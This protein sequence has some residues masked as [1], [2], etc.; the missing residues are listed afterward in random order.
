L[1]III[2]LLIIFRYAISALK[3]TPNDLRQLFQLENVQKLQEQR[4]EEKEINK[5]R[6]MK[7][8]DENGT[9]R[10]EENDG[11]EDEEEGMEVDY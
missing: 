8:E 4:W 7:M 11:R 9:K 5:K 1:K 2:D 3:R 10:K 6:Q